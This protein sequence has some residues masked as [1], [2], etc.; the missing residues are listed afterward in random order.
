VSSDRQRN[1]LLS[2]KC[3]VVSERTGI[4]LVDKQRDCWL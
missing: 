4:V 3:E 1:C 2:Q